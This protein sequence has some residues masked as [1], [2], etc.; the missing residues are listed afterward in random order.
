MWSSTAKRCQ[1]RCSTSAST[2][3][4]APKPRWRKGVDA[5]LLPAQAREPSRGETLERRLLRCGARAWRAAW[6]VQGDHPDRDAAGGVRDGRD[7]L[8]AARPYRWAELRPLG[9]YLLVHQAPRQEQD[10]PHARSVGNDDGQGVPQCLFAPAHQDVPPPRRL[11]DGRH[12]GADPGQRRQDRRTKRPSP[13]SAP[14]RSARPAT[15]TTAPGSRIPI[16]CRS[17]WKCST[18]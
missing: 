6:D 9:L 13:K 8:R 3:S 1:A 18:G 10:L 15:V 16:L 11:R 7:S 4:I 14:T 12:G 17:R 5:G 2:S